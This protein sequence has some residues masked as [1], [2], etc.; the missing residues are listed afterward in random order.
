MV[1]RKPRVGWRNRNYLARLSEATEE[2]GL[3]ARVS[4]GR[5]LKYRK[6]KHRSTPTGLPRLLLWIRGAATAAVDLH[7]VYHFFWL[8]SFSISSLSLFPPLRRRKPPR[9]PRFSASSRQTS[10]Y[11]RLLSSL[12]LLLYVSVARLVEYPPFLQFPSLNTTIYTCTVLFFLNSISSERIII[13][14]ALVHIWRLQGT[15][16]TITCP[17]FYRATVLG[18]ST[19]WIDFILPKLWLYSVFGLYACMF[20]FPDKYVRCIIH[21]VIVGKE[22]REREKS[23]SVSFSNLVL[24]KAS[25]EICAVWRLPVPLYKMAKY[26]K[27]KKEMNRNVTRR[28]NNCESKR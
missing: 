12:W 1:A 14:M 15:N 8:S 22:R 4:C 16:A 26:S 27:W 5:R 24:Y 2:K 20:S 3:V 6:F 28:N 11:T 23:Y 25:L 19:L 17:I 13:K 18:F 21:F 7:F 10:L 9:S